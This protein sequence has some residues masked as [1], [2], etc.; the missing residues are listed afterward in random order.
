MTMRR[1]HQW[2][3]VWELEEVEAR[4]ADTALPHH[5]RIEVEGETIIVLTNGSSLLDSRH[6]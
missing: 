2:W 1:L 6:T 3:V 4:R 5:S